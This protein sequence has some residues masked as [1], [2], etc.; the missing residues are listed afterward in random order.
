MYN[1]VLD[2]YI[3]ASRGLGDDITKCDLFV[4]GQHPHM[5][6]LAAGCVQLACANDHRRSCTARPSKERVRVV[7]LM[8][9][10]A[11]PT[12]T[13]RGPHQPAQQLL[14]AARDAPQGRR[15]GS[16]ALCRI[17]APASLA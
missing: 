7:L 14:V 17:A 1:A 6:L 9:A 11:G 15:Y 10:P 3:E 8:Q 12:R 4:W 16:M 13:C 5:L 2:R